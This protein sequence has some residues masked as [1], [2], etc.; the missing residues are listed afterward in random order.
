ME[1]FTFL[2]VAAMAVVRS[3]RAQSPQP[4]PNTP[5]NIP[6]AFDCN[7]RQFALQFASEAKLGPHG[8]AVQGG[9]GAAILSDALELDTK[10]KKF[11]TLPSASLPQSED[12]GSNVEQGRSTGEG[13]A[14]VDAVAVAVVVDAVHGIDPTP[15]TGARRNDGA[16]TI[17]SVHNP[18]KTIDAALSAIRLRRSS[19]SSSSR[20]TLYLR[21]GMT[22][23]LANTI[24]IGLEDSGLTISTYPNDP[25]PGTISGGIPIPTS[26][27]W[28]PYDVHGGKNIW[29]V[30][31]ASLNLDD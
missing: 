9:K 6:P 5:A 7:M 25:T 16:A 18:F 19:S 4:V 21:G 20:S 26:A 30:D 27:Q 8:W 15:Q 28:Q 22:H 31:L 3:E 17:G 12:G 1:P 24:S 14:N 29:S 10:C 23:W 2:A 13:T 11:D